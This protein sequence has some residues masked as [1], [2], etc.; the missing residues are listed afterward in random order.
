M[1][2]KLPSEILLL[3]FAITLL[4]P[5][6]VYAAVDFDSGNVDTST[7]DQVLQPVMKIY[8]FIKYAASAVAGIVLLLAGLTYM[9]SGANPGKRETAKNMATF[10]VVGLIVIWATPFIVNYITA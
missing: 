7:F 5:Q 3:I 4:G 6:L 9:T 2:M 10:V 8:S 1:K